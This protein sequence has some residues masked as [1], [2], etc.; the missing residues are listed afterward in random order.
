MPRSVFDFENEDRVESPERL[1]EY[2]RVVN[3]GTWV[4]VS[5]LFLVLV[6]F[7]VWGFTGTIPQTEVFKCVVD[8]T[9]GY[10]LDVVVNAEQ[11]FGKSLIGKEATYRLTSGVSGK[12]KVVDASETPFSREEMAELLE[13]DFLTSALVESNYSYILLVEPEGDLSKHGLEIGEI[14]V[15]TDEVRPVSF[16]LH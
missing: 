16:L 11:F 13:S 8:E 3:P 10:G 2:I 1:N 15:I 12:A 4:M 14:A 7:I 5:G 6:A 9:T